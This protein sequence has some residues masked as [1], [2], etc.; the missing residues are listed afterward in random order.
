MELGQENGEGGVCVQHSLRSVCLGAH[1]CA[2]PRYKYTS[3]SLYSCVPLGPSLTVC[4]IY[5]RFV[6]MRLLVCSQMC[7]CVQKCLD[8]CGRQGY[9]LI[10]RAETLSQRGQTHTHC[11]LG[12]RAWVC[13]AAW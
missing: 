2:G 11:L 10:A 12:T 9:Q 8:A 6:W 3:I 13:V 1:P 4:V 7:L 5:P